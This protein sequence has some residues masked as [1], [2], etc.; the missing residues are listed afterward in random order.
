MRRSV[1]I[2]KKVGNARA[3]DHLGTGMKEY[4]KNVLSSFARLLSKHSLV[5]K[6]VRAK[7]TREFQLPEAGRSQCEPKTQA[8]CL[9]KVT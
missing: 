7:S 6:M 8:F 2:V 5:S 9:C 4:N 1:D 3:L